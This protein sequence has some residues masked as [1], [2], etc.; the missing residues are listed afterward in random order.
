MQYLYIDT[1]SAL[2]E[3][4]EHAATKRAVAVDTEF[5]RTRTFYPQLGLVQLFE[6]EQA[7][8]VD[9]IAIDDCSS[10]VALL[11]NP[12]V[13]KVLHAPSEDLEAFQHA[14]SMYPTPMFDTQT[15]A[16]LLGI[17][18]TMGYGRMVEA[19]LEVSLEKGESR[20]DW[21]R[22]PLSPEQLSYA[23]DDVIYLLPC[24]EQLTERL[25]PHQAR[26]VRD[27]MALLI[28]RKSAVMP[29]EFAYLGFKNTWKLA[30]RN[31]YVLKEL[32]AWRLRYA[33]E[34]DVTVN[35]VTRELG[36][37]EIARDLPKHKGALFH[38]DLLAP[39]EARKHHA[40]F[41]DIVHT[42]LA[43]SDAELPDAVPRLTD[44]NG[45]KKL[46]A[47]IKAH[48]QPLADQLGLDITFVA[49]KRQISQLISYYWTAMDETRAQELQPELLTYWRGEALA[50]K[51]L[52]LLQK[53]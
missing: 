22:R 36:L 20:T 29:P 24:Y 35:F 47:E 5:V 48:C 51:L 7:A 31:L 45:F 46:S 38:M 4:C 44:R 42:A 9:V 1:P 12:N 34:H 39:Q 8:L 50:D 6:G 40:V 14:F 37:F 53:S 15:A 3:Y 28:D 13:V 52:P 16:Q 32:A 11:T 21:L 23:A 41:L 19:L 2:R 49:S 27:E 43:L 10:L 17:G 26:I 18:N 25:T 30:P 33:R